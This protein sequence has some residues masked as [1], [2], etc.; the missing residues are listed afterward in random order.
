MS[1]EAPAASFVLARERLLSVVDPHMSLKVTSLCEVLAT[2]GNVADKRFYSRV[3][4]KMDLEPASSAVALAA[5][6][7]LEGLLAGVYQRMRLKVA[8]G[9]EHL[10]AAIDWTNERSLTRMDSN[11]S[12]DVTGFIKLAEALSERTEENLFGATLLLNFL[13]AR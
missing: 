7:T 12:L 3:R 9:N 2:S 10:L 1:C 13:V 4:S 6:L 5:D 8:L 11:V